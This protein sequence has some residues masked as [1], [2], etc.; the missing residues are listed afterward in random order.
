MVNGE[1]GEPYDYLGATTGI[2]FS[3]DGGR[4]AY[5]ALVGSK[6]RLVV[7]D[8]SPLPLGEGQGV[9][10]SQIE[11]HNPH[12][13]SLPTN[14]R[15]VP[16]EGTLYDNLGNL[17]FSPDGKQLA[18]GAL[19]G[20]KW[21]VVVDGREGKPFEAIAADS[22]QFSP[23]GAR[24]AYVAQSGGKWSV[25]A[26]SHEG[27]AY[28]NLGTLHFSPNGK[29]LAY[30]ASTGTATMV[31][32]D[33][34]E[35]PSFD[36]VGGNTLVFSLDNQHF[37]YIAKLGRATFAVV[38]GRRKHRY[39]MVGYL[40]FSPDGQHCVYAATKGAEAFTV[41]DGQEGAQRYQ[42]IWTVPEAR[43]I[44]DSPRKFHYLAVKDDDIL[45]VEE[46]VE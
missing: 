36:R 1:E 22:L 46:E 26:G 20:K 23:D 34:R 25:V 21:C 30:S 7:N 18:Y 44:F 6:W 19:A 29:R 17:A 3:P 43:L 24:L 40:T 16:G 45:L 13:S 35:G 15:S 10:A 9:R 37:G 31:V 38:D 32:L 12:P 39:D 28:D 4:L 42:S 8:I 2:H 14:L 11:S 41:V 5:A 33:G 27:K